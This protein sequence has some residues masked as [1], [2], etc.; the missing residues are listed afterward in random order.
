M[1][2][3]FPINEFEWIEDLISQFNEDSIENYNKESD[4]ENL[5][6]LQSVKHLKNK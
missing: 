2:Q 3:E 5:H 1:S 6:I 4:E